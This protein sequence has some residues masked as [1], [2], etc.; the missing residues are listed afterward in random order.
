MGTY[1]GDFHIHIGQSG[2]K[3]V[4]VTASRDLTIRAIA[5]E[6]INRKGMDLVSLVDFLSPAVQKEARDMLDSGELSTHCRG[7]LIYRDRLLIIPGAEM[8]VECGRGS[9]HW[10]AFFPT[11]DAI[12]DFTG[13]IR[14][15]VG[16]IHLGT[17]RV[18]VDLHTL[19]LKVAEH[20]GII[21]PA[22][23]F[24]PHR[25]FY[26]T[27]GSS[28]RNELGKYFEL[29]HAV[30]LGL[31]ADTHLADFISE[32][33]GK[34]FLSNSDAHS[35]GKIGRE[36]NVLSLE[37]LCWEEVLLCLRRQKGREIIANHGLDPRL[38]KYYRTYCRD[39]GT[40]ASGEPPVHTCENCK[41]NKVVTGVLDRIYE[42]KDREVSKSPVHRSPYHHQIPLEFVPGIGKKLL[43]RLIDRFGNEMNVLH[44]ASFG[45][46]AETVGDKLAGSIDLAR[47][48]RYRVEEGG[49]GVYGRLVKDME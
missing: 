6:C 27:C 31:S 5:D 33:E 2:G 47:S 28:L 30:E 20:E 16:N 7:G 21:I 36:Y 34:T 17:Q 23:A 15:Y 45:E 14:K 1:Y 25:S 9:S 48:G 11:L 49:G 13:F 39:C 44:R 22:H 43:N 3:P 32:L 26:G 41:G 29:I 8:E 18:G 40:R 42:I 19:I 4:K 10:L 12:R 37:E 24:T 38:G 35:A 46:L